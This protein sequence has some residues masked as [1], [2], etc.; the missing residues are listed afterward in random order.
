MARVDNIPKFQIYL[1]H[2]KIVKFGFDFVFILNSLISTMC[3]NFKSFNGASS[4][5]CV[6]FVFGS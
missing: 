2:S 1:N 6:I 3:E 4:G 5:H